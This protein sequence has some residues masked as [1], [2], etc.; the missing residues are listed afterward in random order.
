MF[1]KSL[2]ISKE[3]LII[4]E[5]EFRKGINLIIDESQGQITGNSVG[6]TTVLKLIDFC[7]GADKKN[8]WIEP[9]NPKEVYQLV[10]D[11]LIEKRY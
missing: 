6:K 2:T 10:K 4:R 11:Y 9:E 8:I 1:L 7:L 5:I 3:A